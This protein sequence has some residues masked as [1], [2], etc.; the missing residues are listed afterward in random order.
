M[1]GWCW[2]KGLGLMTTFSLLPLLSL[3]PLFSSLL[4]FVRA[5]LTVCSCSLAN[6]REYV[7]QHIPHR[8][9]D[10]RGGRGGCSMLGE[11][12]AVSC[13]GYVQCLLPQS[14]IL[15]SKP[16]Q[17]QSLFCNDNYAIV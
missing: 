6:M 8:I 3:G 2:A 13:C 11:A 4:A 7:L 17:N 15:N 12:G 9:H 14:L 5:H 16:D 10:C 1:V